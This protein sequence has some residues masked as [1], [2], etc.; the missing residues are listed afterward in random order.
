MKISQKYLSNNDV[1][2]GYKSE[3]RKEGWRGCKNYFNDK[4]QFVGE[5]TYMTGLSVTA[6]D[7]RSRRVFIGK[8]SDLMN[9]EERGHEKKNIAFC[10]PAL[11]G[12]HVSY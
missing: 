10:W 2:I 9:T 3:G 6:D 1:V 7:S 11:K 12:V 4:L 5:I 8:C